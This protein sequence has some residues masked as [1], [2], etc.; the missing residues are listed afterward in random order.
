MTEDG[1]LVMSDA[2]R[3]AGA[4]E[5]YHVG[6]TLIEAQRDHLKAIV[7]NLK[8]KME[9]DKKTFVDAAKMHHKGDVDAKEGALQDAKDLLD[10]AKLQH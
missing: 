4:L 2:Q 10:K 5:E 8:E 7:D 3:L 1:G 6:L 9:I